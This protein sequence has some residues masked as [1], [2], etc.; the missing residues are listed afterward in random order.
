MMWVTYRQASQFLARALSRRRAGKGAEEYRTPQQWFQNLA[1]YFLFSPR[2]GVVTAFISGDERTPVYVQHQV[3]N[4][5]LVD[6]PHH[7]DA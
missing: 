3:P 7:Y 4:Y 6:K 5:E 2:C 1:M